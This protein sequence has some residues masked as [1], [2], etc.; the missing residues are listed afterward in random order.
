MAAAG[1]TTFSLAVLEELELH[2]FL[3]NLT[4]L[5]SVSGGSLTAAYYALFRQNPE[6]DWKDIRSK[7]RDLISPRS[8]FL[9]SF[10]PTIS[11]RLLLPIML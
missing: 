6:W 1:R 3:R 9:S 10:C 2:G 5:S 8:F 11:F 4:A 7:F